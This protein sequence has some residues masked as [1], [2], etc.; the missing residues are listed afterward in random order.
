MKTPLGEIETTINKFKKVGIG[1]FISL[2]I[3]LF[4]ILIDTRVAG[5]LSVVLLMLLVP[6]CL[7]IEELVE[8][9]KSLHRLEET[10]EQAR[11]IE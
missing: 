4:S 10:L 7:H 9:K 2:L 5:M 11:G 6:V 3:A 1:L 8:L